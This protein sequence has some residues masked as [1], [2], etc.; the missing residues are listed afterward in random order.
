MKRNF[1]K[2]SL[3]LNIVLAVLS[4]LFTVIHSSC[5]AYVTSEGFIAFLYYVKTFFDL[6]AMFVGYTTIIFAFSRFDVKNGFISICTFSVSF[7]LYFIFQIIGNCI[8][9]SSEL[10]AHPAEFL[11]SVVFYS[12]GQS[13]L[14]QMAP[15]L[16]IAL[17]TYKLTM[18]DTQKIKKFISWKNKTQRTMIIS[19]VGFFALSFISYT[20]LTVLPELITQLKLYN[21]RIHYEFFEFIVVLYVELVVFYLVMQYLVYHFMY[22]IY[23][24]YVLTHPEKNATKN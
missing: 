11:T 5:T 8:V 22:K 18:N 16:I 21:G 3:T 7:G 10:V 1:F 14:T 20:C 23:D 15:A 4:A 9:R 12:F 2:F 17:L 6:L 24:K 13:F 19:T